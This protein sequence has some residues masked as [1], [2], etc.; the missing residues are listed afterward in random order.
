MSSGSAVR[1]IRPQNPSNNNA[2][3]RDVHVSSRF[4]SDKAVTN[5]PST[6]PAN[7]QANLFIHQSQNVSR[8]EGSQHTWNG[9]GNQSQHPQHAHDLRPQPTRQVYPEFLSFSKTALLQLNWAWEG[10]KDSFR[11]NHVVNI[12][13]SDG[14]IR[15]HSSTLSFIFVCWVDSYYCFEFVWRA[16]GLS[17]A[18]RVRY[19][20]ERW[21]YFLAFG[22]PTTALCYLGNSL[23]NVAIFALIFPSYIILAMY[24][25]PTP[26]QPYSPAPPVLSR[27]TG[28]TI[29]PL[30][31]PLVPVRLPVFQLVIWINDWVIRGIDVMTGGR[32]RPSTA[33]RKQWYGDDEHAESGLPLKAPGRS[34]GNDSSSLRQRTHVE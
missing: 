10:L 33:S 7:S 18:A 28:E 32:R 9:P 6:I 30:P 29:Y 19:L 4:S 15:A 21:A 26:T 5:P 23:V 31:S 24:A 22:L 27:T 12:V 17:L 2:P 13:I 16:K 3:L 34:A 11:W 25:H 1:R 14:E 20:E 8:Y